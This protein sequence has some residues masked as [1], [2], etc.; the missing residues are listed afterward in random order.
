MVLQEHNLAKDQ[1]EW[2]GEEL[3]KT[4]YRLQ[5]EGPL[6]HVLKMIQQAGQVWDEALAEALFFQKALEEEKKRKTATFQW[7]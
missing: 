2:L 1:N 3:R 7:I 4:R 6:D 5:G